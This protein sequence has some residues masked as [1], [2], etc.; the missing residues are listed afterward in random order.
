MKQSRDGSRA[1]NRARGGCGLRSG[2]VSVHMHGY[3]VVPTSI[4]LSIEKKRVN[5]DTCGVQKFQVR[6]MICRPAKATRLP[7]I[8]LVFIPDSD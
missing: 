5:F 3:K 8:C 1:V 4:Q 6:Q 2:V 7:N